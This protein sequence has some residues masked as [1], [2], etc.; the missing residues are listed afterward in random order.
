MTDIAPKPQVER[1]VRGDAGQAIIA[2][3]I[4][5]RKRV[6]DVGFGGGSLTKLL[7]P[8]KCTVIEINEATLDTASLPQLLGDEKAVDVIV[9]R[10]I[11]KH[12]HDPTHALSE[13]GALLSANGYVIAPIPNV[14]HGAIRLALSAG[15]L[16]F[17][18]LGI[19][20]ESYLQFLTASTA[21]DLF[22]AAGLCI[23]EIERVKLG[24]FEKSDLLPDLS[25]GDFD[26][27]LIAEIE[28]DPENDTL[29]FIVKAH[30]LTG[31]EK[32][33]ALLK[34]FTIANIDDAAHRSL[35]ESNREA[36]T[37]REILSALRSMLADNALDERRGDYLTRLNSLPTRTNRR[38][39]KTGS[40][41]HP[42]EGVESELHR[43]LVRNE[44]LAERVDEAEQRL[45]D[46]VEALIVTTQAESARLALLIDTVQ[47]SH[48]WRLKRWIGRVLRPYRR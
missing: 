36:E 45:V 41:E 34:R 4:G 31:P 2:R 27:R 28:R 9:F 7:S 16:D 30:P 1:T 40:L 13:A 25:R 18:S 24:I 22:L 42:Q 37:L 32:Q 12:L 43:E 46:M 44:Y 29:Q 17:R 47:A 3:M 11:L 19:G 26:P 23:D 48:F 15:I 20:D 38:M 5:K 21:E 14:L 35:L 6:L 10:D 33:R 39:Q 8:S